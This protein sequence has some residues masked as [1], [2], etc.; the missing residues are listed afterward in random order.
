MILAAYPPAVQ[1][2]LIAAASVVLVPFGAWLVVRAWHRP[3]LAVAAMILL[4]AVPWRTG[5]EGQALL[6]ITLS[7]IASVVLIGVVVVRTMWRPSVTDGR[8]LA[9]WV[10]LPLLGLVVA[11]TVA[12]FFATDPLSSLSG[13][14][15]QIQLLVMVPLAAYLSYRQKA[16]IRLVLAAV[17]GLG[18]VQG[19]IGITQY[20]TNTGASFGGE[21]VRAVGTFGAYNIMALPGVVATALMVSVAIALVHRGAARG[22]AIAAMTVL[23]P[24]LGMSLSRGYW[25]ATAVGV[26]AVVAIVDRRKAAVLVLAGSLGVAGML[27]MAA[28]GATNPVVDRLVGSTGIVT[29][30]DQSVQDRY[31]LWAAAKG[32]WQDNPVTG[33]GIKN[34]ADYRDSY[35]DF[36]FSGVSDIADAQGGFRQV[37]LL[38]PHNLYLLVLSEQGMVGALAYLLFLVSLGWAGTS[39]ASRELRDNGEPLVQ[40]LGLSSVGLLLTYLTGAIYGDPGGAVGLM[41][42][43]V[44]FGGLLFL[45]SG[46]R[47]DETTEPDDT[48]EPSTPTKVTA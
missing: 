30:P 28:G 6:H 24:A 45:A 44:V 32:M 2:L 20:V 41:D 43:A 27:A 4:S 18:I 31:A 23:V 14:V 26:L 9:S 36:N 22:W 11:S 5:D 35:V 16:D 25:L 33:V 13:A 21:D 12:T 1:V 38:T 48:D 47:L 39:R 37:S 15:R 34:F 3:A 40:V 46:S 29:E 17:L 10:M 42:S 8:R 19:A 7:D